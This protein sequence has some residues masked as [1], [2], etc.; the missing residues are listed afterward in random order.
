MM[1]LRQRLILACD[2]LELSD[3]ALPGEVSRARQTASHLAMPAE[4]PLSPSSAGFS[5]LSNP[6]L[7]AFD[8]IEVDPVI[9]A[10]VG[11][12][13]GEGGMSGWGGSETGSKQFVDAIL[14]AMSGM[15]VQSPKR[16]ASNTTTEPTTAMGVGSSGTELRR[17]RTQT[18]ALDEGACVICLDIEVAVEFWP[19]RHAVCCGGC[20]AHVRTCPMCRQNIE[21]I[22]PWRPMGTTTIKRHF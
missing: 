11:G 4:E 10:F 1:I 16:G 17:R 18:E 7:A 3:F 15:T 20:A 14:G 6:G 13:G 9:Q 2:S 5:R 8:P 21:H 22:Q 12:G 19:C